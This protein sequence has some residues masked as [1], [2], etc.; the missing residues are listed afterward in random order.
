VRSH[1]GIIPYSVSR[2]QIQYILLS[3]KFFKPSVYILK[4]ST[5]STGNSEAH[6][7]VFNDMKIL[8][9]ML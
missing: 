6:T 2:E 9:F 3:H 5:F 8:K 4:N 7:T 1:S